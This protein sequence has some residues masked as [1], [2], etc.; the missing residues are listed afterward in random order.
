MGPVEEGRGRSAI[1]GER[2]IDGDDAVVKISAE[3]LLGERRA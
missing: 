3:T 2:G 1:G